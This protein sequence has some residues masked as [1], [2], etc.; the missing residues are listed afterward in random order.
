ML[1]GALLRDA[2]GA[3]AAFA[4]V[5]SA[6]AQHEGNVAHAARA[7][8]VSHRALRDW[9]SEHVAIRQALRDARRAKKRRAARRFLEERS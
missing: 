7:L 5:T 6:I 8:G 3:T 9:A 1:L 4:K 2:E